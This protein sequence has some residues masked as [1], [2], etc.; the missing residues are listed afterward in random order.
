MLVIFKSSSE[1]NKYN[2]KI[3]NPSIYP[4]SQ[5]KNVNNKSIYLIVLC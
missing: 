2:L 4:F 3:Y 1:L 5:K